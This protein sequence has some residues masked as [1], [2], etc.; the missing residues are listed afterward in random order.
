MTKFS[1]TP[2]NVSSTK[3]AHRSIRTYIEQTELRT[4]LRAAM[5]F[6]EWPEDPVIAEFGCGFGRLLPVAS[7]FSDHVWGFEREPGLASLAHKLTEATIARVTNLWDVGGNFGQE[8]DLSYSF[9]VLQHMSDLDAKKVI[10]AMLAV[11]K[12]FIIIGE[13]T[14]PRY[15]FVDK[16]DNSHFTHGRSVKWYSKALEPMV[17]RG[18]K[19][20]HV[21]PGYKKLGTPRAIVGHWML[22]ERVVR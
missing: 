1:W 9:T 5:N 19:A 3:T 20:R 15:H 10:D 2:E 18:I 11:T 14:D 4:M 12:S 13:D 17:L 21:E 6:S 22:F 7:E 8:I 16:S